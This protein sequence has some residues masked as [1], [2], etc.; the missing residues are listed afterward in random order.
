MDEEPNPIKDILYETIDELTEQ[1]IQENIVQGNAPEIINKIIE[2]S[3]NKV[4]KLEGSQEA[5]TAKLL[6]S[7]L[8]YLLTLVVIPSQRKITSDDIDIDIVIPDLKTMK[9]NPNEAILICI[10]EIHDLSLEKQIQ[11]MEKIQINKNNIWYI[12]EK[13]LDS[14]TYSIKNK[15]ILKIIDDINIFLSSKKTTQFRFLKS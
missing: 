3:Q 7:L 2:S 6:T 15:T 11:H 5:N 8:H 9:S 14:K 1:N 13:K 12:T 10:P 4:S